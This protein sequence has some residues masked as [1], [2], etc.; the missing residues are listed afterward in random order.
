MIWS[1]TWNMIKIIVN[2]LKYPFYA[3]IILLAIFSFLISINVIIGLVQGKRFKKGQHNII[4]RKV[5][6]NVFL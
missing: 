2:M 6:L 1:I 4:K 5:F 3:I